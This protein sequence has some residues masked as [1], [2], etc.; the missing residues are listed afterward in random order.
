MDLAFEKLKGLNFLSQFPAGSPKMEKTNVSQNST[1]FFEASSNPKLFL[2]HNPI[3]EIFPNALAYLFLNGVIYLKHFLEQEQEQEKEKNKN[4]KGAQIAENEGNPIGDHKSGESDYISAEGDIDDADVEKIRK[5]EKIPDLED[6]SSDDGK[7]KA[8]S[9]SQHNYGDGDDYAHLQHGSQMGA[10][11]YLQM[12][13][14]QHQHEKRKEEEEDKLKDKLK[15]NQHPGSQEIRRF[16][17][18]N[19]LSKKNFSR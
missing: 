6:E 2:P 12:F 11:D 8:N 17:T 15:D 14:D 18:I 5:A 13:M 4:K 3:L 10:G 19:F 7:H 16:F 9:H 1:P